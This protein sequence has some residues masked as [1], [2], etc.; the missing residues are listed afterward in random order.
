LD[1]TLLRFEAA[2]GRRRICGKAA[3]IINFL[4]YVPLIRAAGVSIC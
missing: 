1:A 4:L 3:K 2:K